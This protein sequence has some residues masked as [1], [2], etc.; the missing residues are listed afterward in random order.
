MLPGLNCHVRTLRQRDKVKDEK[1]AKGGSGGTT[2]VVYECR[3]CGRESRYSVPKP[4]RVKGVQ[5]MA[6]VKA[7]GAGRVDKVKKK[8][9]KKGKGKNTLANVVA[10]AKRDGGGGGGG[11]GNGAGGGFGLDLMDLMKM[12]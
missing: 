10:A 6:Q 4:R 8:K 2:V 1:E 7:G 9:G 12:E 11:G 5:A 3:V